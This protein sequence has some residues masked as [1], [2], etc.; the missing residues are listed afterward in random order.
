MTIHKIPVTINEKTTEDTKYFD[1][2]TLDNPLKLSVGTLY[3]EHTLLIGIVA[4]ALIMGVL[5][6]YFQSRNFGELNDALSRKAERAEHMERNSSICRAMVEKNATMMHE[7]AKDDEII[8]EEI[9][10]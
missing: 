1:A 2:K 5:A 9:K 4:G 8:M 7:D 6:M 10:K 3:R